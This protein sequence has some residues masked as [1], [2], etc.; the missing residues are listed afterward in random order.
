MECKYRSRLAELPVEL[1]CEIAEMPYQKGMRASTKRNKIL[2]ILRKY[3]IE[4]TELGTGTNR[5][6]VKYKGYALKTALDNEGVADNKQEWVMSTPLRRGC[7]IA[8][9]ISKGGN[10]LMADYAG[11]FQS[12]SEMY[13][14]RDKILEILGYWNSMGFLL[15]DVGLSRINYANWGLLPT[16]E[17]VCIDYAYIFPANMDLFECECGSNNIS[18]IDNFTGYKC[19]KCGK[20]YQD[21]ELRMRISNQTRLELFNGVSGVK[22]HRPEEVHPVDEKY[23]VRKVNDNPDV[24]SD[25]E[26][27]LRMANMDLSYGSGGNWYRI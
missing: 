14:Y 10:L 20:E 11:A 4:F 5:F 1:K 17:P 18:A 12:Y 22:M 27:A 3:D 13:V 8:R 9:E 7:A 23:I 6:I 15:G 19:I 25:E 16:G 21:R 24:I 26:V 2:E